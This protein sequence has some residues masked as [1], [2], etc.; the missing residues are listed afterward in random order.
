[1]D[2]ERKARVGI[3]LGLLLYWFRYCVKDFKHMAS[4]GKDPRDDY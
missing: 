3:N 2:K 4:M 1:M